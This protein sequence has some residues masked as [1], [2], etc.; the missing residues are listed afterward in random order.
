MEKI[1]IK[2]LVEFRRKSDIR[3][4]NFAFKLKTRQ[5]KEVV[6]EEDKGSSGD[7]WSISTYCIY[8]VFKDRNRDLYDSKIE[9]FQ[10]KLKNTELATNTQ[11]MYKQNIDI[12]TNFKDFDFSDIRPSKITKFE[13]VHK[14]NKIFTIDNLPL[15]INP[16][17]V[18]SHERNGKNE[19]GALWLVPLIK[20]FSKPEL[21]IFCEILYRFMIKNYSDKYQISPD[22]CIAVD[23]FLAQKVV[24][25]DLLNN[26][27]PFLVDK[28]IKEIKEL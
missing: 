28:T 21:G 2:E 13:T 17:L 16:S 8:N 6:K 9:E 10:A 3:K 5:P 12:M 25:T 26:E 27:I 24:Y 1:R 15:F 4:K 18:F 22:Y 7:Y 19:I 11:G 23:T 20:G 14:A